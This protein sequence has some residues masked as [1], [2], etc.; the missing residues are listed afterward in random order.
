MT[1]GRAAGGSRGRSERAG[2]ARAWL[3]GAAGLA[4]AV[5]VLACTLF[6]LSRGAGQRHDSGRAALGAAAARAGGPGCAGRAPTGRETCVDGLDA[7][8]DRSPS[9]SR[10]PVVGVGGHDCRAPGGG[11][12]AGSALVLARPIPADPLV[13]GPR[14]AWTG[15]PAAR[16]ITSP[17]HGQID[18][19]V[20]TLSITCDRRERVASSTAYF[21][22][23]RR[24]LAPGGSPVDGLDASGESRRVRGT[25]V[26]TARAPLGSD[27]GPPGGGLIRRGEAGARTTEGALTAGYPH[28]PLAGEELTEGPF[29]PA[30]RSDD[31]D[32]VRRANL[33]LEDFTPGG[34]PGGWRA[35][36]ARWPAEHMTVSGPPAPRCR[37]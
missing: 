36:H 27:T 18:I 28:M 21:G 14:T 25:E 19:V 4:L 34:A 23:G 15:I 24:P 37:D 5:A 32:L 2:N 13:P 29:G 26:P 33:I 9:A 6:D 10:P 12:P 1:D 11:E 30:T 22:T 16:R 17:P 8:A 3:V 7:A 35:S 20:R 31:A